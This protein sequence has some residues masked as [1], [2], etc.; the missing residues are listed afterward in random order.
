M[1]NVSE[2][3]SMP[4]LI[5][6]LEKVLVFKANWSKWFDY[7]TVKVQIL[8]ILRFFLVSF[9]YYYSENKNKKRRHKRSKSHYVESYN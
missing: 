5:W 2:R 3:D 8:A 7:D 4:V 1:M 9:D 6:S